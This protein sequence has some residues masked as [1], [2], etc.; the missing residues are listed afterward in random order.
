MF[1]TIAALRK[2]SAMQSRVTTVENYL[3]KRAKAYT[4]DMIFPIA[5]IAES[6]SGADFQWVEGVTSTHSKKGY[7]NGVHLDLTAIKVDDYDKLSAAKRT[8]AVVKAVNEKLSN[9]TTPWTWQDGIWPTAEN[10]VTPADASGKPAWPFPT[11]K[12]AEDAN[13]KAA[14]PK[15]EKTAKPAKEPAKKAAKPTKKS[16]AAKKQ[17]KVKEVK[18]NWL[19]AAIP[20]NGTVSSGEK[21]KQRKAVREALKKLVGSKHIDGTVVKTG[22]AEV[23]TIVL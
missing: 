19:T 10:A 3:K 15:K 9:P 13:V 6:N 20:A 1:T 21:T 16:P 2:S 23:F 12:E 11:G 4:P 17:P 22:K 7:V 14:K 18:P 8:E 5:I